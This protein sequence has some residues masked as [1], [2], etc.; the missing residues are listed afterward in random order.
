MK[1]T[2]ITPVALAIAAMSFACSDTTS[3]SNLI[4]TDAAVT[5]DVATSSG[6][7]IAQ[8]VA[9][10]MANENLGGL[11]GLVA[12]NMV[13]VEAPLPNYTRT[14]TCYDA[15]GAVVA[16]CSPI[17]SVRKVVTHV[18]IDGSRS[19]SSTTEGGTT[20]TWSGAV[21]R[22]AD[23]TVQRVFNTAQPPAE[24]QRVHSAISAG[25]DTTTF[26]EGT[27]SR[28]AAETSKDTVKALTWNLPRT[29]NP[30]PV[31]GKVIRAVAV[32]MVATRENKTETRDV[33]RVVE[34]D[35]PADAQGN[36]V[37]KING[38]TCNLNLV[39]HS[40]TNCQ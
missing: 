40:V 6:D 35:F 20:K 22:V 3:L 18:K 16:N 31:S 32:H 21:H 8:S 33:T 29:T 4:A 23:D 10:M 2:K 24:T 39:N 25:N 38:K 7:A 28:F 9:D 34:V 19:G 27:T 17:A 13:S 12:S 14:R 5:A 1:I 15:N 37:L 11:P 30:W 36:V 26:T